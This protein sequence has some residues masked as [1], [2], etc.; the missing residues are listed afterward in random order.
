MAST[1]RPSSSRAPAARAPRPP[2]WLARTAAD[3]PGR[4]PAERWFAGK[5]RGVG[6]VR[7]IEWTAVPGTGAAL[8]LFEVAADAGPAE[9]YFVPLPA[10]DGAAA[11]PL[12]DPALAAALVALM[13]AGGVLPGVRGLFRFTATAALGEMLPEPPRTSRALG[14]EQSNSSRVLGERAV[15]KVIRRVE[16]G[17]NPELELTRFL[18]EET[19]FREAP[20]L[21]GAVVWEGPGGPFTLATVHELVAAEGDG[22]T[23]LQGRLDEYFGALGAG[24]GEVA[25]DP[26]YARA[27]AAA[28]AREAGALGGL[29]GRLHRALAGAPAG[30]PLAPEPITAA[31]VQ[32]WRDEMDAR[33]ARAAEALRAAQA[34]LTGEA[35]ETAGRLLADLP[36]LREPLAGL[37]L[38][39]EGGVAKLRL[40]GDY[41]LGQVLRTR[42][43]FAVV[44][45]EGEPARP[46]AARQAKACALRDVAGMLRSF[47]YAVRVALHRAVEAAPDQPRLLERLVPW[48]EAWEDGVRDAFLDEYLAAA[49]PR[50]SAAFLPARREALEAAL[51]AFE[52]DKAVY[53]LDYELN[54]R[55]SWVRIPLD[56]LARLAAGPAA[57]PR[58]AR[59]RPGEGPFRFVACL[60][61]REFVGVRAENERQLADL[62]EVVPLDSI[63]FHTHGFL[64]RHRFAAGLYPNDFATWV[65]VHLRDQVLGERLAMVD[66]GEFPTLQALREEL[67]AVVDDHLRQLPLVPRALSAEPFYFVRSR[68]VEVPTGAEARTLAELRAA[69]LEVDVSAIFFHLVEARLRLGRG[70][71]DFAAWFEHALGLPELAARARHVSPY[72][73]SLER[74]RSRLIQLCDEAL[75]EGG[76]GISR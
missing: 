28:D 63:Y 76:P 12:D 9:T 50:G 33:L 16:P 24:H 47:G 38:L 10:E 62:I 69:L 41:H 56:T 55:P 32:A 2:H 30:H 74:I 25:A 20:R 35:A 58:P 22:W 57:R 23:V 3:L 60:E 1:R 34:V 48:A 18:T 75:A 7:P 26:A 19:G 5:S 11:E 43:G 46:L 53:E 68:I 70:Q 44:D 31:D 45:F 54:H 73:A 66:P 51:R 65:A 42:D 4:L 59:L 15:L 27:L 37:G 36:R 6:R 17:L 61:L 71:N 8:V 14:A 72:G 40:H 49:G 67:V 39:A 64:L 21:G 13:R 52:T 29:T